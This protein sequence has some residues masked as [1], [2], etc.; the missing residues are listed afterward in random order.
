MPPFPD[1]IRLRFRQAAKP[2][3][4]LLGLGVPVLLATTPARAAD[5]T[6]ELEPVVV[7][8]TRSEKTLVDTPI[9][10]EVVDR[11]EIE[12]SHAR[13]LKQALENVPGL[14]LRE[15]HGKS[16]YEVSLQGLTSDQVLILVD[17]LPITPSTG[18]TVDL[19]QY[20]LNDVER[21]EVVKGATSAQ[22][23]S[24][25]MGGVINVITRRIR[26][27]LWGSASADVGTRGGQNASGRSLDA[28]IGH[29]RLRVEGGGERWRMRVQG[30]MLDD[31]G[32]AVDPKRWAR[33]GDAVRRAQYAGRFEWLPL[34]GALLWVEGS[35]YREEA[36][37][38]FDF[39]APPSYVPQSKVERIDR[40]RIVYG[41]SWAGRNGLR[42]EIK[43]VEE[44]YDSDSDGFSNGVLLRA[45]E[46]AQ[47]TSHVTA[48]VDLP[49]WHRQLWQF[50][51]D[52]HRETL[53]QRSNGV[54]ELGSRGHSERASR[55]FFVQNDILFDD[56]WELLL[57]MRWQD[58]SDFGAHGAAKA[59][60]RAHLPLGPAWS[61]SVRA[62]FG[63]GYRVPNLKER[64][65][66][67]DHSSLGYMV[68]GNPNLKPESS[69]SFQLGANFDYR[70]QVS[71]E[72]NLFDNR[73]EDLIQ[74]DEDN[75][76][77]VNGITTYTYR[78]IARARTSGIET[79]ATWRVRPDLDLR[80]GYTRTRARNEDTG[81]ELTRRPRDMVRI[82]L[83]WRF[84]P[85]ATVSVRGRYQSSELVNTQGG[86]RSPG[87]TALD[88]K[89]NWLVGRATTLF[90]GID[91]LFDRQRDFGNSNDFGPLS[92][93]V[94]YLGV[95]HD[96]GN[97]Y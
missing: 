31:E 62:S 41:G 55:E 79:G 34:P 26:P 54:S 30:D 83:D 75:A 17:G 74:V 85:D 23:G 28:A 69:N 81:Q 66:L 94:V 53:R 20:L 57:G 5:V 9:R 33:Q 45:R 77:T 48:Q 44:Q 70:K 58:D 96:F 63:Q 89:L 43:G 36:K 49:V 18:S 27:G 51:V 76:T 92:G 1:G 64:H 50:G 78:N 2:C 87:W 46:A 6:A 68:V 73:V 47:R 7:T 42:A 25:A 24:S 12:R 91:N 86:G 60:L 10:T 67:F 40:D 95:R 3:L 72:V 65:F 21:V 11:R 15:V 19:S 8:A 52:W 16:G 97:T 82:G 29:A 90:A 61:G 56:T 14:Q 59:S 80:A 22:Y 13:T 4:S 84:R 32:F 35:A 38:R 39:F 93:R 71:F 37:Q 88:L